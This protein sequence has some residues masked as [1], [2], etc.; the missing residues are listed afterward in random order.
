[1]RVGNGSAAG[2]GGS[3]SGSRVYG[4][5]AMAGRRNGTGRHHSRLGGSVEY[6]VVAEPVAWRRGTRS[7]WGR[8]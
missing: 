2:G 4:R 6:E 8:G 1:M 3:A 7:V 5:T